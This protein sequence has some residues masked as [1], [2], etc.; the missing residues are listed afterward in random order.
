[1]KRLLTIGVATLLLLGSSC[2]STTPSAEARAESNDTYNASS[3]SVMVDIFQTWEEQRIALTMLA[4]EQARK[5]KLNNNAVQI[6]KMVKGLKKRIG[7][8]PYVFSGSSIYG[9]DCSGLVLWAYKEYFGLDL[10]HGAT[11]QSRSGERT[12]NPK[13][14]DLVVFSYNG[15]SNAYHVGIY[16]SED[17]MIHAG[18]KRGQW[19]SIESIADWAGNYSRVSYVRLIENE[20]LPAPVVV[21]EEESAK[22]STLRAM[23]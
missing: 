11:T 20:L 12:K 5:E 15:S 2:A 8:T 6:Q 16:L 1:M 9:W 7:K 18:G 4:E 10:Y 17:K 21:E 19:T 14:G 23:G 13:L 22:A 3:P